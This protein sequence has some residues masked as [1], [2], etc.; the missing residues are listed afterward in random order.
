M[1]QTFFGFS[2]TVEGPTPGSRVRLWPLS[3]RNGP[4]AC[5]PVY[6]RQATLPAKSVAQS[7]RKSFDCRTGYEPR[8]GLSPSWADA[9]AGRA[10]ASGES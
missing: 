6:R 2:E 9:T 8:V 3:A 5:E 7:V 4:F 1:P 10:S